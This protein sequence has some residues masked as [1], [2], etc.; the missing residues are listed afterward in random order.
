MSRVMVIF[1]SMF[2]NTEEVA[3]AVAEG[4]GR[5][6]SVEVLE[7]GTAPSSPAEDVALVVVGGPTHAFG[8]SRTATR[9]EAAD[10]RV[11]P[12]VSPGIGVREWLEV[13]EPRA[14]RRGAAFGT[15]MG[16][17]W[18]PWS[19]ARK[20]HRGLRRRGLAPV[21]PA[22]S[23]RVAGIEGPLVEGELAKAVGWGEQLAAAVA[24]PASGVS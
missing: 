5:H 8:M 4:L 15:R 10:R 14:G 18:L 23:F 13:A 24:V 21:G 16:P 17:R 19:A 3:R 1:E 6:V 9:R 22:R 20:I 2:G 12:P 7:V 11:R